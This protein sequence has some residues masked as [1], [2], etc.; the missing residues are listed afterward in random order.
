MNYRARQEKIL[1]LMPENSIF[2]LFN[3]RYNEDAGI[4]DCN[5]N[6]YYLSGVTEFDDILLLVKNKKE[7][8]TK[9]YIHEIDLQQER[10][11]GKTL[12]NGEAREI[13][14]VD[15]IGYI[16]NFYN[17]IFNY[18]DK[19]TKIYIL[20]PEDDTKN[21]CYENY[22]MRKINNE[23]RANFINGNNLLKELRTIKTKEEA[24]LIR[25]ANLITDKGLNAILDN[26][27][28]GLKEYQIES[29]FDQAIKYNGATG[30][31]F[32]TI[33]ASG[34]NSTCLHYSANTCTLMDGDLILFDLGASYKTYCADV[35]RT[36]PINGK[37]TDKQKQVYEIVLNGQKLIE[38]LAKPGLTTKDLN[39]SLIEYYI[40][41]LK[42]LGL[43]KNNEEI[44]KYYFHAVSHHLGMDCH[45]FCIYDK[46]KPGCII[47]NEP[48]LYIPEWKIGIRIEDDLYITEDGNINLSEGIIKEVADIENYLA[49]RNK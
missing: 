37:F 4:Y 8:K 33:A 19:K 47:S 18:I 9:L 29:Y 48:G 15:D 32:P 25:Q 16:N 22:F 27:K 12:R 35:S 38:K 3:P 49:K 36:Y 39:N 44:R 20:L 26:L 31:S 13:A 17:D 40:P 1:D 43:I 46:L 2:C 7:T 5:R 28:P 6:F 21:Y 45:D 23:I 14:M 41:H 42:K 11:T 10:W 24:D 34:I 30:Y